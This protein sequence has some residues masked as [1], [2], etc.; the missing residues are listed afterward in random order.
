MFQIHRIPRNI[1]ITYERWNVMALLVRYSGVSYYIRKT[2]RCCSWCEAIT[3]YEKDSCFVIIVRYSFV[4]KLFYIN[5]NFHGSIEIWIN[6]FFYNFNIKIIKLLLF[7]HRYGAGATSGFSG[8]HFR[9]N[10]RRSAERF[11]SKWNHL[12]GRL[13]LRNWKRD[14]HTSE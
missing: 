6:F 5:K 1:P 14:T 11:R 13:G 4:S 10:V 9:R 3:S 2:W 7:V 8:D 12:L